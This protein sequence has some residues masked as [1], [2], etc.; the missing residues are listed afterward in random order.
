LPPLLIF[1]ISVLDTMA[2]EVQMNFEIKTQSNLFILTCLLK[3]ICCAKLCQ[4]N[5][6]K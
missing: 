4:G 6:N 1:A 2:D 3:N 5:T